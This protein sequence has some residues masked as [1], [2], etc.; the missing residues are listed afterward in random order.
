MNNEL[1]RKS[2]ELEQTLSK[3]IQLLKKDSEEWLKIG[4]VVLVAGIVTYG[5]VKA[6]KKKSESKT[7]KAI[8]ALEKEGLLTKD[9][10]QKLRRS[11]KSGFW[12]SLTERLLIAGFALVK[13]KFLTNLLQ[14]QPENAQIPEKRQ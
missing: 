4:A 7:E 12:P 14:P 13:E 11:D 6:T 3:Q 1:E 9:I 10:E 2:A 8:L 5:L